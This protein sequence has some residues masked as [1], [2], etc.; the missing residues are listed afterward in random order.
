VDGGVNT[1]C[2]LSVAAAQADWVGLE[3]LGESDRGEVERW[4]ERVIVIV[5]GPLREILVRDEDAIEE[6]NDA[7]EGV[8]A[9]DDDEFDPTR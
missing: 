9:G 2:A 1:E 5:D 8:M 6:A 7:V 4:R 3:R